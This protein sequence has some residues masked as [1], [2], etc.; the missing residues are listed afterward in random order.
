MRDV[1]K[2]VVNKNNN[3]LVINKQAVHKQIINMQ[4]NNK[5]FINKQLI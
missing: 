5:L 1:N 4:D 2:W 3:W